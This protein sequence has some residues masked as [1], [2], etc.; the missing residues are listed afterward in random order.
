M[1]FNL[2]AATRP[3]GCGVYEMY[4]KVS[5]NKDG[6]GYSYV[7]NEGTLSQYKFP[8]PPKQEI[9]LSPYIGVETKI[10][11]RIKKKMNGQN[12]EFS[13]ILSTE[14]IAPDPAMLTKNHGFFLVKKENCE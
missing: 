4:G 7:L 12:G 13:E 6:P 14:H 1:S 9:K 10:K 8:L 11:A 3:S 2:S 5:K